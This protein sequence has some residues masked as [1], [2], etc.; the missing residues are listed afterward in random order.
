MNYERR[1]LPNVLLAELARLSMHCQ[2]SA[3][4]TGH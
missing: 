4:Q 2:Y 1:D 3:A